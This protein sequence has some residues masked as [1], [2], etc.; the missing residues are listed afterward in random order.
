MLNFTKIFFL[1]GQFSSALCDLSAALTWLNKGA[2]LSYTLTLTMV[3][4][5]AHLWRIPGLHH[6]HS[7]QSPAPSNDP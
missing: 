6:S 4:I 5:S 3:H 1:K 7:T 2:D